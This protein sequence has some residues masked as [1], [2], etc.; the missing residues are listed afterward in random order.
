MIWQLEI[1]LFMYMRTVCNIWGLAEGQFSDPLLVFRVRTSE[2]NLINKS[3]SR[4][5][6]W[7]NEIQNILNEPLKMFSGGSA[8]ERG[9][10]ANKMLFVLV[11][12]S[13]SQLLS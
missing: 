8:D 5:S 10:A 1:E 11:A 12:E 6:K 7:N 13:P 2:Q 3:A 4:N 9:A